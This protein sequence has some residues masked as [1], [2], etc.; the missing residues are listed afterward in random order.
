[1][2]DLSDKEFKKILEQKKQ[3]VSLLTQSLTA[4]VRRNSERMGRTKV[5]KA[6]RKLQ[7]KIDE[8]KAFV[9]QER[10]FSQVSLMEDRIF[11]EAKAKIFF[12]NPKEEMKKI[13][14]PRR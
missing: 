11:S 6:A 9:H 12:T 2:P 13:E 3:E 14:K 7:E 5:K 1:M 4:I 10:P 8:A